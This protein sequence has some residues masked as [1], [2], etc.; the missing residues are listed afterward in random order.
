M[1]M[2]ESRL[3]DAKSRLLDTCNNIE[4]AAAFCSEKY[5]VNP[6]SNTFDESLELATQSVCAVAHE[7]N[8]FANQFLE[9][10][11]YQS[12]QTN[13]LSDKISK[14]KMVCN[15][16]QEKMARKAVGSCTVSKVP[17]IYQHEPVLPEP[18][19]KYVRQPINFSILDN[20]G[21]G[22]PTQDAISNQYGQ[23]FIQ[24]A[25]LTRRGSSSLSGQLPGRQHSTV[26]CRTANSKPCFEYAAP[27]N[28]VRPQ[29]GTVG[30][31]TVICRGGMLPP[32]QFLNACGPVAMQHVPIGT[33]SSVGSISSN[34]ASSAASC[35]NS[36]T[37]N[38]D[39]S[40]TAVGNARSRKSSGSSGAGSN[41]AQYHHGH[42]ASSQPYIQSPNNEQMMHASHITYNKTT[43]QP[44]YMASQISHAVVNGTTQST[45]SSNEQQHSFPDRNEV[46]ATG[47]MHMF[48]SQQQNKRVT[49][50]QVVD[51]PEILQSQMQQQ[52][53]QQ[54]LPQCQQNVRDSVAYQ[55]Q[56]TVE[57]NKNIIKMNQLNIASQAAPNSQSH[58]TTGNEAPD[59][60]L[61]IP[62]P[63]A[64]LYD[65]ERESQGNQIKGQETNFGDPL[66]MQ[67]SRLIPRQAGD[68]AWAPDFYIEKVITMYE[69]IR[70]KDDELTFTENQIIYVIKKND[71]GWWEGIMNGI[72]GLFPGNYVEPFDTE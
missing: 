6:E 16:Y 34:Y 41:A 58:Q 10:L 11:E 21:H 17:V 60:H 47:Q 20:V 3:A 39:I 72:T 36:R 5:L 66:A 28:S 30:R 9:A 65:N 59:E 8:R 46:V 40:C 7:V 33:N 14:L 44:Q 49:P 2:I 57:M 51:R 13:D 55:K 25:T 15:I 54:Q 48:Q 45:H 29:V 64:F 68:P 52:T 38:H 26:A 43:I 63:G 69:Y 31:A 22:I 35:I 53:I 50:V 71:D 37:V 70:D 23:P 42:Y 1:T 24:T 27:M 4:K 32:Q 67:N 18:P 56:S 19:Q 12:Y 62:P 61:T